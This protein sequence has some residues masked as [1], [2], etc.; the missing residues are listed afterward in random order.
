V[1]ISSTPSNGEFIGSTCPR[2]PRKKKKKLWSSSSSSTFHLPL[3]AVQIHIR[4]TIVMA[5]L[6]G[7]VASAITFGTVVA[8]LTSSIT[9]LKDFCEQIRNIPSDINWLVRDIEILGLI[10]SDIEAEFVQKSITPGLNDSKHVR[11]S[12]EFCREAALSLETTYK[13]LAQD[14]Q[15]GSRVPQSYAIMKLVMR[16][17]KIEKYKSRLEDVIRLLL[18]SQQCYTRSVKFLCLFEVKKK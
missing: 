15:S 10:L 1:R 4:S 8:Q 9:S 16:R 5:E 3:Q 18:L 6:V 14:I 11:Q 12:L 17:S 7:V 2:Q 13:D